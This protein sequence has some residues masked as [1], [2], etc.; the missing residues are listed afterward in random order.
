MRRLFLTVTAFCFVCATALFFMEFPL[1][2][3]SSSTP[4]FSERKIERSGFE[5]KLEK[6]LEQIAPYFRRNQFTP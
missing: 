3:R 6:G 1:S 5:R 4:T 2:K